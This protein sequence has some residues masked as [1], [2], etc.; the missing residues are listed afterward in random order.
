[1][2]S[3]LNAK[4][5]GK[6]FTKAKKLWKTKMIT[7]GLIATTLLSNTSCS[8]PQKKYE[9]WETKTELINTQ[10]KAK[11]LISAYNEYYDLYEKGKKTLVE[12]NASGDITGYQ[13]EYNRLKE[14]YETI[15]NTESKIDNLRDE[16]FKLEQEYQEGKAATNSKWAPTLP[17]LKRRTFIEHK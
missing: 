8:S 14:L 1:M 3:K 4:E 16:S 6:Q 15:K 5:I 9:S 2:G 13:S 17:I 7:A 10:K 12:L 11:E